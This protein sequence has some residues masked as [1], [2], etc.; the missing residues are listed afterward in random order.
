MRI[1]KSHVCFASE[2]G[3]VRRTRLCL[4]RAKSGHGLLRDSSDYLSFWSGLAIQTLKE[5][6]DI[7]VCNVVHLIC[8][9]M[10]YESGA[11][12]FEFSRRTMEEHWRAGYNDAISALG[13]REVLELPDRIAGVRTFDFARS[14]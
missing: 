10:T 6:A 2:S 14:D 5:E 3:H 7:K 1:A 9:C 8:Y 11:K 13:H 12:D 4:L